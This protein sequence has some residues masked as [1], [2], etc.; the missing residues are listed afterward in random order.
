MK[1]MN[2][3]F[4]IKIIIKIFTYLFDDRHKICNKCYDNLEMNMDVLCPLCRQ[5]EEF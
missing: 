3:L 5:I 4:V 1:M 2:V